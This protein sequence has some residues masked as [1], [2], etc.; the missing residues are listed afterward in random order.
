MGL[1]FWLVERLLVEEDDNE[2]EGGCDIIIVGCCVCCGCESK[3]ELE[4]EI[5]PSASSLVFLF[6][7][8]VVDWLSSRGGKVPMDCMGF[9]G[10]LLILL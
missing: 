8:V 9:W 7:L 6:E 3:L 4:L 10:R 5:D 1:L 2:S